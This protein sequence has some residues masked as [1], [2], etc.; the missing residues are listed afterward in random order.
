MNPENHCVIATL[1]RRRFLHLAAASGVTLIF[2]AQGA[3]TAAPPNAPAVASGP[4]AL[5]PLPYAFDALEPHIDTQTMQIH[6]G[7]HH[8]AYVNNLNAALKDAPATS[9]TRASTICCGI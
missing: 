2:A 8:A 5:P 9:A 4:F 3:A 6:H 1:D 7:K